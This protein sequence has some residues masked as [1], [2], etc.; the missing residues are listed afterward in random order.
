MSKPIQ[1][2]SDVDTAHVFEHVVAESRPVVMRGIAADWPLVEKA[3]SSTADADDYLRSLYQGAPVHAFKSD[4]DIGGRIFYTDDLGDNNFQRVSTQLDAVLDS[5]KEY[6]ESDSTATLYM[7]SAPID[8]C[9]P[10]LSEHNSLQS[11]GAEASVRIWIGNKTTVAAHYDAM[12]NI[13]CVCAGRRQFTLFPPEQL[14][15]LYV[16][17]ID[18]TP[19][20]QAVSLVDLDEPDFEQFPR[21]ATALEHA[22]SAVLEPGDAIYIPSMWW[23]HVKGL[24]DFNILINH[25]WRQCPAF[26]GAPHDALLHAILNIRDLPEAQRQAWRDTFDFY[27]FNSSEENVRHI[28]ADKRGVVGEL[29][30]TAT[31]TLRANLRNKLNR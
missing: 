19:A 9:L 12:D 24:E 21:F 30:E 28:P 26:M 31:R 5:L 20:G 27:V 1:E 18:F 29:D 22:Q 14:E 3:L 15:N 16:G 8:L 4:N 2:I 7:G 17:P 10:G 23:H 25:W 11:E 13:A 6:R